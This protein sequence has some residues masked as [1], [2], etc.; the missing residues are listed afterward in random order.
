[1]LDG[2]LR[3]GQAR[4]VTRCLNVPRNCVEVGG[5]LTQRIDQAFGGGCSFVYLGELAIRSLGFGLCDGLQPY[6]EA[7]M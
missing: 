7:L 2:Q 6:F 1:M 4:S 5:L 3:T